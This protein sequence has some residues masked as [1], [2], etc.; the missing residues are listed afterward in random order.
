MPS[1]ILKKSVLEKTIGKKLPLDKLKERISMLGTDLEKIENDDIYVEIFPNR[2]DL[3]SEQGFSRA[4]ASFL[5]IT[6]GLKDYKIKP[7]QYKVIIDKSVAKIRPYTV[8]AV[9]KNLKLDDDKIREIIQ[10][11]EKL[12]TTHCRNIRKSGMGLYPINNLKFPMYYT[13]LSK[14]KIKYKPLG[15]QTEVSADYILENHPKGKAYGYL[16]QGQKNYPIFQDNNKKICSLIPIVN[17]AETGKVDINTTE[18]FIEFTGNN[19]NNV[20]VGLNMMVTTLADMGGDIYAVEMIYPDKS[21]S[22]PNLNPAEM[23][24]DIKY[25]NK[26]LGLSLSEKEIIKLL[27]KMGFGYKNN[28]VLIPAYRADILHPADLIEDIAIAYG[29]ENFEETIPNIAT[30]AEEN[31]FEKFKKKIVYLLIG[32]NYMEI[33]T[34]H[35]IPK[36]AQKEQMLTTQEVVSIIDSVSIEFNSLRSWLLPSTLLVLKDNKHNEFPQ[37]IFEIATIFLPNKQTATTIEEQQ[38]LTIALCES[39]ADYTKIRQVVD[40]ILRMLALE[41]EI[42]ETTHPSFIQG[43]VGEIFVNN[44]SIGFLGELNPEVLSNFTLETPTVAA[45]LNCNILFELIK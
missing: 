35:L 16:L 17:S 32:L 25:C 5:D 22:S 29:Y 18:V 40:Y 27:A 12:H 39:N 4:F 14:E 13:A 2:P 42:K 9:V 20:I 38:H 34:H 36:L 1:I 24:L 41:Y 7:S 37:N 3:L 31:P 11:Q 6:P 15:F 28:K 43:R 8:C 26:L 23:K 21:F 10:F 45:E 30:I 44:K 33:N 19:L